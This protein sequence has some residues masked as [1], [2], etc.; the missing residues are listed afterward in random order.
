M[1][2]TD[3][4]NIY[5]KDRIYIGCDRMMPVISSVNRLTYYSEAIELFEKYLS[6]LEWNQYK[7]NKLKDGQVV[8]ENLDY[9]IEGESCDGIIYFAFDI[10]TIPKEQPQE[11]K[12]ET[13][14]GYC[15]YYGSHSEKCKYKTE[16]PQETQQELW[17]G[18]RECFG[19][20]GNDELA[21][22]QLQERFE[23]LKRKQ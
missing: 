15:G 17:E 9:V 23:P 11:K 16:S 6:T 7:G 2:N 22:K 19:F 20:G 13:K 21:Y 18:V 1:N 8:V 14:C 4:Q 5:Y 10:P 3:K 12:E